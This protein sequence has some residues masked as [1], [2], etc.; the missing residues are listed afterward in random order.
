MMDEIEFDIACHQNKH[1]R[2]IVEMKSY[3]SAEARGVCVNCRKPILPMQP[4]LMLGELHYH[5]NCLGGGV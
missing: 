1:K 5:R 4:Y 2:I 3:C